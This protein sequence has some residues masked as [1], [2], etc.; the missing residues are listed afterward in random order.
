MELIPLLVDCYFLLWVELL[1]GSVVPQMGYLACCSNQ[2]FQAL[3]LPLHTALD[4]KVGWCLTALRSLPW[5]PLGRGSHIE[6]VSVNTQG[7]QIV[8]NSSQVLGFFFVLLFF[9]P[10]S[11][12]IS[13]QRENEIYCASLVSACDI[14]IW[15]WK[16][17]FHFCKPKAHF[18]SS[19]SK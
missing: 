15:R 12:L 4:I 3:I 11:S 14:D 13:L 2:S 7:S 18:L 19:L 17:A 16:P 10:L 9:P 5:F 8:V 6:E 1:K